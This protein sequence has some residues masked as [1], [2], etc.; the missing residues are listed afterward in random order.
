MAKQG[1]NGQWLFGQRCTDASATSEAV[2]NPALDDQHGWDHILEITPPQNMLLPA[3]LR[4][5]VIACF[6]QIK[7]TKG[8]KPK[9]T[10]KLSNAVKAAKSNLPSFVFLFHYI[11]GAEPVLYGRHIW[12]DEIRHCLRRARK[13]GSKQLHKMTV[14][15]KFTEAD[16]LTCNPVDWVL[17]VLSTCG[18][19][20]YAKDKSDYVASVGY[21]NMAHTGK[22]TVGPLNSYN[23]LVLHELGLV[24]DLP[25]SNFQLFDNRFGITSDTPI[26]ALSEG[27]VKFSQDGRKVSV[28]LTSN[29]GDELEIPGLA[30]A[31]SFIG[32]DHPEF[33]IR[34]KAGHF[35]IVARTSDM[36]ERLETQLDI[37]FDTAT[38]F[39]FID[40]LGLL[41]IFNWAPL[42]PVTAR[43]DT[44]EGPLFRATV[45]LDEP[46]ENWAENSWTCAK[47]LLDV[48]GREKCQNIKLALSD[49]NTMMQEHYPLAVLHDSSS[50]RFEGELKDEM[51]SFEKLSGYSYGS[52]DSWTFWLIHEMAVTDRS[53]DGG[54]KT[55][56]LTTPKIVRKA[57]FKRPLDQTKE[58]AIDEF[59]QYLEWQSAAVATFEDGDLAA[60]T[61][62]YKSKCDVN[63]KVH[64]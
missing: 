3:D 16:R 38:T 12:K 44:E 13:A 18:G 14:T 25:I 6:V 61:K 64:K 37:K 34:V 28:M 10:V 56:K 54:K 50:I 27:R 8:K 43:I 19:L 48:L 46:V 58:H 39:P 29:S 51:Q 41:A 4:T 26:Q 60:W 49:L 59:R 2:V 11:K 55:L 17:A 30:W 42:G 47:Y 1:R 32:P 57:V 63:I 22:F 21:E 20:S 15:I 62:G 24:E 7:T 5:P 40:Q 45:T 23:E 33:M 35:N 53:S 52:F 31:P 36:V 9:T